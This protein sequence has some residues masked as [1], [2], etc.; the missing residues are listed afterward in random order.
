MINENDK[1]E[2]QRLF[3]RYDGLGSTQLSEVNRKAR[4]IKICEDLANVN[5]NK[6][7]SY[8]HNNEIVMG[9]IFLLLKQ[10]NSD[11]TNLIV[12]FAT[13]KVRYIKINKN[14]MTG[15]SEN[16]NADIVMTYGE[17][18]AEIDYI[19][20]EYMNKLKTHAKRVGSGIIW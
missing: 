5:R 8:E 4:L 13:N 10:I 6:K 20:T 3:E 2:T 9:M 17:L 18:Y 14:V 16:K 15:L 11:T 1:N 7:G 19:P 12:K